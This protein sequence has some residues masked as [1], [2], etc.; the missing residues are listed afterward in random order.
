MTYD[1]CSAVDGQVKGKGAGSN[2]KIAEEQA[3]LNSWSQ[4]GW[5]TGKLGNELYIL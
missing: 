1:F 2:K 4:L 5:G 3:A